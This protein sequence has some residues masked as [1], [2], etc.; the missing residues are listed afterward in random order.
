MVGRSGGTLTMIVDRS[1]R[2]PAAGARRHAA[3]GLAYRA[4]V[5]L[6]GAGLVAVGLVLVPL[7][8]PGWPVVFLGF[9]VLGSEFA[10][11]GRVRHTA[12]DHV[13]RATRW[14]ASAPWPARAALKAALVASLVVPALAM[15]GRL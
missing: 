8:G 3:V 2:A 13:T 5:G 7:P 4:A 12:Q 1:V 11:A 9:V 15:T 14:S 6:A 10:C